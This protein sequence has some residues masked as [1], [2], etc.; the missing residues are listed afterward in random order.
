MFLLVIQKILGLLVNTW[1]T[2]DK[3]S[4]LDRDKL[5]QPIQMQISKKTKK[6]FLFLCFWDLDQNLNFWK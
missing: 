3:Y 6:I 4:L 2:N 5:T 1:T